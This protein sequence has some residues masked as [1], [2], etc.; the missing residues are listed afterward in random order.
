M[1][2][3]HKPSRGSDEPRKSDEAS[4]TSAERIERVAVFTTAFR[5]DLAYWIANE[6]KTALRA[7]EL[8]KDVMR[9]PFRGLGKPEPL[10]Y[11]ASNTWSRRLTAEHRLV[12][13]VAGEQIDFLQARYHYD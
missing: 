12:Y 3:K 6:P 9:D 7:L 2:K 4:E 8:V 1:A 5:E 13:R 11:I 10:K